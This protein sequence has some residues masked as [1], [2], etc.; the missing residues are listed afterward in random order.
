M[1]G[2]ERAD[3]FDAMDAVSKYSLRLVAAMLGSVAANV[4]SFLALKEWAASVWSQGWCQFALW[5]LL[6]AVLGAGV[7]AFFVSLLYRRLVKRLSEAKDAEIAE[8]SERPTVEDIE[9]ITSKLNNA[10]DPE[11]KR[12]E[13]MKEALH[14]MTRDEACAA[15]RCLSQGGPVRFEG[16]WDEDA[17]RL[18]GGKKFVTT[19][20]GALLE[21]DVFCLT[22]EWMAFLREPEN[23]RILD[24]TAEGCA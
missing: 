1:A 11:R 19:W 24:M 18:D 4:V 9:S 8:L 2:T 20:D 3:A 21:T 14:G 15:L 12:R 17:V 5:S 13:H 10:L 16:P 6:A 23:R 7:A 22:P